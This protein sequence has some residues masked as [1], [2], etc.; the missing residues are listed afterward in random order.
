MSDVLPL[1]LVRVKRG[2]CPGCG[3]PLP[4][5]DDAPSVVCRAC[6]CDA[7]V[8]RR[9]RTT[10][11]ELPGTPLRMEFGEGSPAAGD[12]APPATTWLR[13]TRFRQGDVQDV[14]C[15]GC[16][17]SLKVNDQ[18]GAVDV[19]RC[20]ACGTDARFERRLVALR[21]TPAGA[22]AAM[23]L[24]P[25]PRSAEEPRCLDDDAVDDP[26]SEH[27]IWR[28]VNEREPQKRVALALNL[29]RSEF[30]NGT[31][32][33]FVPA[34][35]AAMHERGDSADDATRRAF[36]QAIAEGLGRLQ[37]DGRVALRD[38]VLVAAEPWL[39]RPGTSRAL[40]AS[41][42]LGSPVGLKMLLDSAEWA[43]RRPHAEGEEHAAA[44]L[45]AVNW[46]FQRNFD[47][48]ASMGEVLLYRMLY[49]SGP[50]LAFALGV[51]QRQI[52]GTGFHYDAATL[53]RFIE[54]AEAERPTLVPDLERAFYVG[55]PSDAAELRGRLALFA[56]L[57]GAAA[58]SAALR[59]VLGPPSEAD[60]AACAELV[61]LLE[62]L[63]EDHRL[64]EPAA[65]CLRSVVE[66]SREVPAA[67]H[68][69]VARR[70]DRL[71]AELRRHYLAAVPN[72]PHLDP[73]AIPYWTSPVAPEPSPEFTAALAR[74]KIA[75]GSA[76]DHDSANREAL[77]DFWSAQSH[78][79]EGAAASVFE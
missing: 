73:S 65:A 35:I 5:D 18:P 68:A 30:T 46:L 41:L 8:E 62:S 2:I 12:A 31:V 53:L 54:D 43:C 13:S 75:L 52:T 72:T 74:W 21:R 49:L 3:L 7:V 19:L 11:P 44:C 38:A 77:R 64:A 37:N 63:L 32:A 34:L 29:L 28:I 50:A 59:H 36:E 70:G 67:I 42:G 71:P 78:S 26:R 25:R 16:G 23:A 51:A 69:L 15:P 66:H 24:Q 48:H 10:E 56:K 45:N 22:D 39:F 9:L 4:L 27:L 58:K 55:L 14:A 20:D 57:R 60:D 1:S 61:A 76:I 17:I 79:P 6:G 33:R 47:A 40:I